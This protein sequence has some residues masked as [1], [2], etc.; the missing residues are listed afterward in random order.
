MSPWT[1]SGDSDAGS[2]LVHIFSQMVQL[3][4]KRL[5]KVPEKNFLAFLDLIGTQ[6]KPPQPAQ[7]PLTFHLA[8]GSPRDAVVPALTQVAA[9]PASGETEEII[10]ETDGDLVV[11]PA[12]L[13][14][15]FVRD[16]IA[17]RYGDYTVVVK[18][19]GDKSFPAF[20]GDRP[21]EHSLYLACDNFFTLPVSKTVT[22]T[23][24][25]SEAARLAALPIAWY[26]WDSSKHHQELNC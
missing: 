20:S 7:V 8:T 17:D 12:Q 23:I 15:V 24:H 3:A 10:F 9:P 13:T 14:S 21:I 6:I 18:E 25:S 5:N 4:I 11:T 26:Y 19:P 22:L 2:A 1:A 16:P